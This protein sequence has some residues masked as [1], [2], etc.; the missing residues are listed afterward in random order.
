M[1]E[2]PVTELVIK[3]IEQM[4]YNEGFKSLKFKNRHG[5]IFQDTEWIPGVDCDR[6]DLEIRTGESNEESEPYEPDYLAGVPE[7]VEMD[8]EEIDPDEIDDIL[9]DVESNPNEYQGQD[10]EESVTN[11]PDYLAREPE[12]D[13][14]VDP[15]KQELHEEQEEPNEGQEHEETAQ[16]ED[17][18]SQQ[19]NVR[20]S[21]RATRPVEQLDPTMKGKSYL[22]EERTT[23]ETYKDD[24]MQLEY[25]HNLI[26][27]VHPNPIDDVK[28]A[29]LHAMLIA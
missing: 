19:P 10:Q 25:C 7:D 4:A 21:T 18:D 24:V 3:A 13:M 6:N 8:A 26:T 20:R 12:E 22:Q 1:T 23:Q 15:V 16:E 17:E 14:S 5:V 9:H 29:M 27:Q 2:I 28:Y 11:E